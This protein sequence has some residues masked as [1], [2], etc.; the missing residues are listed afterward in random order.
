MCSI[1]F[2]RPSAYDNFLST[3]VDEFP[4]ILLLYHFSTTLQEKYIGS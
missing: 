1:Q 3:Q 4:N 2:G